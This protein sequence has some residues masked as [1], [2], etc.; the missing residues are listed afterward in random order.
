MEK[1]EFRNR[2]IE[3]RKRQG[4]TQEEVAERCKITVRTIQRIESGVVDPR[5]FT[6]KTISDSLGFEFF[7]TS[8]TGYDVTNKYQAYSKLDKHAI[9][10][11]LKDLFNL[12]T[13]AMRK[14]LILSSLSLIIGLLFVFVIDT[15]SQTEKPNNNSLLI[16]FNEDK[17][18]QRIKAVFTNHLTLDSLLSIKNE[19]ELHG[20]TVNYNKIE[21]DRTHRLLSIYADVDCNDG[22]KGSFGIGSLNADN[23]KKRMGFVRDYSK[24]A[25]IP[26]CTGGCGL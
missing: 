26:F 16:Q 13:N 25:K 7:E 23:K 2:L 14:L 3:F 20:I 6:I 12:K 4:L 18:I 10:W 17:S 11:Y 21:F 19:L 5:A 22:Y 24:N 8:N 15:K 1:T 9:L